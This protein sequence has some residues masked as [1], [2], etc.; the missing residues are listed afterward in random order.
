MPMVRSTVTC[1]LWLYRLYIITHQVSLT[2]TPFLPLSP[3]LKCMGHGLAAWKPA[4]SSS[5][6]R[7]SPAACYVYSVS[8]LPK[9]MF[10]VRKENTNETNEESG[11]FFAPVAF[12][13]VIVTPYFFPPS[14]HKDF[15][16]VLF[17]VLLFNLPPRENR[18]EVVCCNI[19]ASHLYP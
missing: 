16:C 17:Y 4:S 11:L 5:S 10:I 19:L 13:P 8:D 2:F 1:W 12:W 18:K 6:S 14:D 3:Q 15:F 9:N 7:F